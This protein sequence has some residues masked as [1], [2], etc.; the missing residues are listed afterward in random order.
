MRL[1]RRGPAALHQALERLVVVGEHRQPRQ[2]QRGVVEDGVGRALRRPGRVELGRADRNHAV[3]VGTGE[4]ERSPRQPPPRRRALVGDVEHARQAARHQADDRRREVGGERRAPALVVHHP[5]LARPG[6]EAQHGADEVGPPGPGQ[7]RRAHH[8]RARREGEDLALARLL[9][10]AVHAERVGPIPF[11]VRIGRLAVEHVVRRHRA[12]MGGH[13]AAAVGHVPAPERVDAP[14]AIGIGLAV[15]DRRPR[16]RVHDRVRA[17]R[18]DRPEH[19]VTVADV[20]IGARSRPSP[21]GRP[22]SNAAAS[23]TPSCPPAP[24][25]RTRTFNASRRPVRRRARGRAA[26][27]TTTGAPRTMRRSRAVRSRSRPLATSRARA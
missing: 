7:P 18:G 17:Q 5:H 3:L 9:G 27:P 15:V 20:E 13:T 6:G 8:A 19:G 25:T 24:V 26:A 1:M 2:A 11:G 16:R 10:P 23:S 12:E 14:R 22:G 21:H 4:G